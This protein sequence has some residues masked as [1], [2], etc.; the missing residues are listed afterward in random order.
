MYNLY[1]IDLLTCRGLRFADSLLTYVFSHF[2]L[3]SKSSS[4]EK[5]RITLKICNTKDRQQ[6]HFIARWRQ[7]VSSSLCSVSCLESS[8]ALE[9]SSSRA[10][11][12]AFTGMVM[13][14]STLPTDRMRY[15]FVND[16]TSSED[17]DDLRLVNRRSTS[18]FIFPPSSLLYPSSRSYDNAEFPPIKRQ[19]F[20]RKHHWDAYFG[21]VMFVWFSRL[22]WSSKKKKNTKNNKTIM[23]SDRN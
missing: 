1:L 4:S 3:I 19:P 13:H 20:G 15:F 9:S 17:Q 12:A 8:T 18:A 11:F 10:F 22:S 16:V 7:V 6:F 23:Q 21:W 2:L 5:C 14:I